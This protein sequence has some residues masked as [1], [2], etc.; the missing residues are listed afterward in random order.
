MNPTDYQHNNPQDSTYLVCR[1]T[2]DQFGRLYL[3]TYYNRHNG[4]DPYCGGRKTWVYSDKFIYSESAPAQTVAGITNLRYSNTNSGHGEPT[5]IVRTY[6][7]ELGKPA[8]DEAIYQNYMILYADVNLKSSTGQWW[9]RVDPKVGFVYDDNNDRLRA[10]MLLNTHA[11][12]Y[13]GGSWNGSQ[14]W[15]PT[16]LINTAAKQIASV[17]VDVS[18]YSGPSVFVRTFALIETGVQFSPLEEIVW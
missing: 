3:K 6:K 12:P 4:G 16:S 8:V 5:R 9:P 10:N 7:P 17:S 18:M 1:N 11:I 14:C 15:A 2:Y 13:N